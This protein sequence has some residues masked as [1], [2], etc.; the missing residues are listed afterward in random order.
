MVTCAI[1]N[2]SDDGEIIQPGQIGI[3]TINRASN[4]RGDTVHLSV[5][6]YVH[7]SCRKVY[8]NPWYISVS[9][10]NEC[11]TSSRKTRTSV[12]TFSCRY[13]ELDIS[14]RQTITERSYDDWALTI[15][16]RLESVNEL[17]VEDAVYHKEC[18]SNFRTNKQ[19]TAKHNT[20][21][22]YTDSNSRK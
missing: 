4:E 7:I 14:I 20:T 13:R 10:K 22:L 17:R 15:F 3:D 8:I 12:C 1:C 19:L 16:G 2:I 21:S 18:Y 11:N 6:D 5:G 9:S